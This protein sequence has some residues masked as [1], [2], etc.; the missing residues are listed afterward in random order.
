MNRL[1]EHGLAQIVRKTG[2]TVAIHGVVFFKPAEIEPIAAN[3]V[4]KPRTDRL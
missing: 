3:S 4:A 1:F 2:K